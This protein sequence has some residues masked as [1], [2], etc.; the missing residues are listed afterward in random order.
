MSKRIADRQ[1]PTKYMKIKCGDANPNGNISLFYKGGCKQELNIEEAYRCVGCG[2]WFHY[3]CILS[4]FRLERGHDNARYSLEKI[5]Y[6]LTKKNKYK[7]STIIKLCDDGLR[8]NEKLNKLSGH[9]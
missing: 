4:H 2:G 8:P 3:E 7:E 5:K 1:P 6:G 9:K